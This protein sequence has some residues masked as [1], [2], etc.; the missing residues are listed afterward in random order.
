MLSMVVYKSLF[1]CS[2]HVGS[3]CRDR[4]AYVKAVSLAREAFDIGLKEGFDMNLLDIGGGFPGQKSAHITMEEVTRL[5]H[6]FVYTPVLKV[7]YVS[8]KATRVN[9]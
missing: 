3:G 7:Y 9:F 1:R 6:K 2:F 4:N 8:K 5:L